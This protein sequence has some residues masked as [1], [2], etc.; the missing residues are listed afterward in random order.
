MVYICLLFEVKIYFVSEN[1]HDDLDKFASTVF[2]G[3]V[4][5]QAFGAFSIVGTLYHKCSGN[6]VCVDFFRLGLACVI[7]SYNSIFDEDQHARYF[8]KC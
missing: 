6:C 4:V 1:L 2:E 7:F 5:R 3:K 8:V